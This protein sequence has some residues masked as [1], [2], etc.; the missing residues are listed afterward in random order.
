MLINQLFTH[1]YRIRC[2]PRPIC[3]SLQKWAMNY[4]LTVRASGRRTLHEEESGGFSTTPLRLPYVPR[5]ATPPSLVPLEAK[6][7]PAK[8]GQMVLAHPLLILKDPIQMPPGERDVRGQ[9][10]EPSKSLM[11]A[12]QTAAKS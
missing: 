2:M 3:P 10:R 12:S 8:D 5:W 4:S 11:H 9:P 1:Q 7:R 6:M